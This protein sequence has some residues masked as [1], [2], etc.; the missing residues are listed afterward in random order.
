MRFNLQDNKIAQ[1]DENHAFFKNCVRF[2][3]HDTEINDTETASVYMQLRSKGKPNTKNTF[4]VRVPEKESSEF[5]HLLTLQ[6]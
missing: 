1:A 6:N 4:F 3:H 5:L 2:N